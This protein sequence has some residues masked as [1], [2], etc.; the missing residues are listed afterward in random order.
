MTRITCRR[1]GIRLSYR[2]RWLWWPQPTHGQLDGFLGRRLHQSLREADNRHLYLSSCLGCSAIALLVEVEEAAVVVSS[3]SS[4]NRLSMARRILTLRLPLVSRSCCCNRRTKD[5]LFMRRMSSAESA[6]ATRAKQV[7]SRKA[8]CKL[9]I[10]YNATRSI[11][12]R[13]CQDTYVIPEI[14]KLSQYS[15]Y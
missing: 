6:I 4:G 10:C 13:T 15:P 2:W 3:S 14:C 11:G 1:Q 8:S 7:N 9:A 5:S 12:W